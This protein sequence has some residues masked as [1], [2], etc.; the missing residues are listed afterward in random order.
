MLEDLLQL[1]PSTPGASVVWWSAGI[2]MLGLFFAVLGTKLSRQTITLAMV[3][4]GALIGKQVPE[5]FNW[6]FTPA[7][8]AT[9]GAVLAGVAGF[10]LHRLWVGVCLGCLVA[11]WSAMGLWMLF[12]GQS[13]W[14]WPSVSADTTLADFARQLWESLNDDIRWP[15]PYLSGGSVVVGVITALIVPRLATVLNWSL[16]GVTLLTIGSLAALQYGKPEWLAKLP[17]E[18]LGQLSIF[19]AMLGISSLLQWKTAPRRRPLP[20][21]EKLEDERG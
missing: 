2:A 20:K 8:P 3:A 9:L 18:N 17:S 11:F 19:G 7:A 5:W 6:N 14:S 12:H 16:F 4:L 13:V 15:L 1:L 21:V 10:A